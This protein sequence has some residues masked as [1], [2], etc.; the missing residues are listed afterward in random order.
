M[1][2]TTIEK[3]K[4]Y[5]AIP[6]AQDIINFVKSFDT[7]DVKTGRYDIHGDDLFAS[8]G[9][10]ATEPAGDRK[11]ENHQTYIDLQILVSGSEEIHWA[12]VETLEMTEESFSKGGDIA[13]YDGDALGSVVLKGNTCAILFENDAHKPNV[14]HKNMENV[15]KIVFKIKNNA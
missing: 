10:Y 14:M 2:V 4:E 6:Y 7:A 13:F 1:I 8:V 11:F 9:A 5:D 12:P 3:I 15:V